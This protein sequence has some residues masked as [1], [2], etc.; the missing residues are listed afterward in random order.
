IGMPSLRDAESAG[1]GSLIADGFESEGPVSLELTG[2]GRLSWSG[3]AGD[4]DAVL[5]GSGGLTIEGSADDTVL[6]LRG[7]GTLDAREL[8]A[9][10]ARIELDGS[11]S[12]S[13]TVNGRVDARVDG[14]GD[15]DLY[16]RV[17]E[18]DFESPD[19]DGVTV[20]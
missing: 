6:S 4:L 9:S 19:G 18:G 10:G 20:H 16:G 11:G 5:A 15:V 13:A 3:R 7:S 8:T 14:S 17:L 1:S 2:S 12:V